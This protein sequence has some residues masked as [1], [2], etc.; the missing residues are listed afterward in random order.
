MCRTAVADPPDGPDPTT[1]AVSSLSPIIFLLLTVRIGALL[2]SSLKLRLNSRWD[3]RTGARLTLPPR[4]ACP[5]DDHTSSPGVKAIALW[6]ADAAL[7]SAGGDGD[8]KLDLRQYQYYPEGAAEE[9][10]SPF[11]QSTA[12]LR[13]IHNQP[14]L[15]PSLVGEAQ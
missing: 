13:H 10:D 12:M 15:K 2:A 4:E 8:G 7:V 6:Y 11:L 1:P 9:E 14:D 3:D 5:R